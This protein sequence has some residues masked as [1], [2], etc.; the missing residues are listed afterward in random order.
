MNRLIYFVLIAVSVALVTGCSKADLLVY[1]DANR[2]QMNDTAT[3]NSTFF[4][5]PAAKIKDT[6]YIQVNTIGKTADYDRAVNLVQ[7]AEKD[8]PNPAVPGLHYLAMDDPSLKPLMV[9]KANTVTAMIPVVLL[10]D[11]SLKNNSYR[12]RLE[13]V[14]NDQFGLGELQRMSRAIRFSD[15]LERFYSWR[16]DNNSYLGKYSTRKH[17]FIIDVLHEQIDENWYQAALKIGALAH[18]KNLLK[19]ALQAYNS[20]P[21]N[22]SSGKA[23]MRETDAV[24]SPLVT[25][26]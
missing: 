22:I 17:Q 16:Q 3:V 25:F 4:Y 8:E 20:N 12:L 9:V 23:P 6:V 2:V 11:P 24:S 1:D 15:R 21:D 7:V 14:A 13:L 10:R 18:Y 19:E 5:E 26:P